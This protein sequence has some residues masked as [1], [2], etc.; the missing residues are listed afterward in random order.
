MTP[1][2]DRRVFFAGVFFGGNMAYTIAIIILLGLVL[3]KIGRCLN[4]PS[5]LF[6]IILGIVLGPFGFNRLAPTFL[7]LGPDL[8]SMALI[9]ILLRAGF[10]L[11]REKLVQVGRPSILL[12][13]IPGMVEGITAMVLSIYFFEFNI[14]QAGMLGFILAA[15]SPAVVVPMMIHLEKEELGTNK[16]IPTMILAAASLDDTVAI[17]FFS[18]F[19]GIHTQGYSS[20]GIMLM[21]LPIMLILGVFLGGI[22]GLTFSKVAKKQPE[23]VFALVAL[24]IC[25]Y[26]LESKIPIASLLGVMTSAAI[27]Q[28]QK[29]DLGRYLSEAMDKIWI[30]A[31][32]FLFVLVGAQVNLNA[33]SSSGAIGLVV[34]VV[35]LF[36]RSL[37]VML[38]LV[39]TNLNLKERI[40]VVISYIP[41]ATVQAAMGG[42]P[43]A[44]GVPHGEV[45]LALSV[46]AIL[47]TTPIGAIGMNL[48]APILLESAKKID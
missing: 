27:I 18:V 2:R 47:L 39:G 22:I 13:F 14:A 40:Y 16:N 15:V 10:G 31:E 41:K 28:E 19:L 24:S 30:V 48:A 3:K 44:L 29:P 1:A 35:A 38:S 8:R 11:K 33:I 46:L 36:M 25:L 37:G 5:L 45:I 21:K 34:I 6:L 20:W 32:I 26:Q 7:E 17:T 9:V 12:S 4:V 42:V 23:S 43:L